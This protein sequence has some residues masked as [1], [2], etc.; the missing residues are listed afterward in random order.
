MKAIV[1]F[2][3]DLEK[4][5]HASKR[6]EDLELESLDRAIGKD[7]FT[8]KNTGSITSGASLFGGP[9][10]GAITLGGPTTVAERKNTGVVKVVD[11]VATAPHLK[12]IFDD[13]MLGL[14]VPRK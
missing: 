9:F 10:A 12:D 5:R 1:M 2:Q 14:V 6:R 11:C 3:Q 8:G 7:H 13:A 4:Q